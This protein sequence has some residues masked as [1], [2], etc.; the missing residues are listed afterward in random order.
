MRV[1]IVGAGTVGQWFAGETAGWL[2]PIFVD[3]NPEQAVNAATKCGGDAWSH[4][5]IT[6]VPIICTAVPLTSTAPVLE[7]YIPYAEE[8]CIDLSGAMRDPLAAMNSGER[9][10]ERISLHPL[11]A[12]ENAPGNIAAVIENEG[13]IW[14]QCLQRLTHAGNN[15]FETTPEYHDRAM[16]TVQAKVHAAIIAFALAAEPVESQFHTPISEELD[17]L[18]R[19][20][21][22]GSP[23]VYADI[24]ATFDGAEIV[25]Q[26]AADI[27]DADSERFEELFWEAKSRIDTSSRDQ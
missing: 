26:A 21:L 16:E 19:S 15:V 10:V 27:A 8:A 20:V 18:A 24:Q 7:Q 14:S 25:A 3:S 2:D 12:P 6:S 1:V 4:D 11:F 23:R 13:P 17:T 5:E 22:T 9:D